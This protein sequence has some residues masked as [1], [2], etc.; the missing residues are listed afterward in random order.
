MGPQ[1]SRAT[2]ACDGIF[3]ARAPLLI[4]GSPECR[5]F[6]RLQHLNRDSARYREV[7]KEGLEHMRFVMRIYDWQIK[8]G[9][10]F[11]H[12]QLSET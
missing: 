2:K 10:Y 9:R 4:M 1:L 6:C 3:E 7:L 8:Q 12:E 5:A 11:L